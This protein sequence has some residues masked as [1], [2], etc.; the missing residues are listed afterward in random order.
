[1]TILLVDV[2]NT[3]VKWTSLKNGKLGRMHAFAHAGK[4]HAM[5]AV[6]RIAPRDTTR[7]LAVN[8]AGARLARGLAAAIRARFG[9]APEY[10]AS[11]RAGF[12]VRNGYREVWRLGADRWVALVGA[13]DLVPR[14]ALLVVSVG[15]AL[16]VD[17]VSAG[18]RH[19]GGAIVPA[20]STM[21][22]SLLG[23]TAGI[24]RRARGAP[25]R[26]T[27]RK[28]WAADTAGGLEAGAVYAA[29]A[30]VD[31]AVAEAATELRSRPV[32][33]LTGGAAAALR[34]H[35]KSVARV[36][37]DLVLRGLAVFARGK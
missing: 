25:A 21:I 8:V 9:V 5:L 7:V 2:G 12:G 36:V 10:V 1:M 20:P 16:T 26:K 24:A 18:G 31:R 30:F 32:V 34:P 28:L 6:A 35:I 23:G 4:P 27:T 17:A 15:T 13:R 29:A 22:A 11:A 33:L 19:A 3:R 14:Q 37:P